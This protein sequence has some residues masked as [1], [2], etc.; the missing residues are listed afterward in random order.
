METDHKSLKHLNSQS[1]R[2]AG[3]QVR[4]HQLFPE[5]G[6]EVKYI[7]GKTNVVADALTM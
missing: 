1:L 5:F 2:A 3:R 6:L 4:W 7:P